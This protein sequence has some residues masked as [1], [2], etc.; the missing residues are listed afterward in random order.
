[1][2]GRGVGHSCRCTR[3]GDR[4]QAVSVAFPE[5]DW[6]RAYGELLER[7]ELGDSAEVSKF[8]LAGSAKF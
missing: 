6:L 4:H 1:M 5:E 8:Q 2:A 7:K 3:S